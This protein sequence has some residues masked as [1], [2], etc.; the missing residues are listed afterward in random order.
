METDL[1]E[2]LR[3]EETSPSATAVPSARQQQL[4]LA[5]QMMDSIDPQVQSANIQAAMPDV[6]GQINEAA[7]NVGDQINEA[8]QNVQDNV[9]DALTNNPQVQAVA[10][11]YGITPPQPQQPNVLS[12]TGAAIAGGAADAVE[13][14]GGFAE[15]TGDTLKTGINTLFGQPVDQTQNPF[16]ELYQHN[17][18]GWLDIPDHIVP[19]NKTALGKLA[20]GLVEFG[21]LTAAT[22]GVGGATAGGARVGLRVAATARAAGIGARGTRYIKFL[23]KGA[24]VAAE[25]GAAE[26]ISSQSE[27]ANLLNLVDDTTPWMSPWVKNVVGVNALKVHP[28]DNPW[29]A[30]IKTVAVGSGVNLVGW[31]ISAYAKGRWAALDARKQGKSIDEA[32]E[33]GNAKL[34][35]EIQLQ[36]DLDERAATEKAVDQYT[37][38]EGI[39]NA[40]PRD[41][42]L[43]KNLT[44]EEYA[45]YNQPPSPDRP[46][47]LE[48]DELAD[49]RGNAAGDAWDYDA[50]ASKSQLET[51]A[52][53]QP[54][55]WVNPRRFD[56]SERAMFRPEEGN[57]VTRNLKEGVEDMKTGS[58]KGRSYSPLFTETA[59]KQMSRGSRDLREYIVE[60]A[61][62]I[63]REAFKS[64]DNQLNYKEVQELIIRQASEMHSALERGGDIAQE[65]RNWFK[66]SDDNIVWTHAGNEVVTGTASEKAALQLVINTLAKQ[67]EGIATGAI[68]A[69][70]DIPVTRQV[71]QVFDAMKVALTE[72]KKIGYM[73]GSELANMKGLQL[74]PARSRQIGKRL[75]E[76]TQEQ[77]EYFEALHKLNKAGRVEEMKDLMEIHA[78]SKGDVRTLEMVHDWLQ[79]KLFGGDI[80]GGKIRGKMRQEIQGVFYNSILSSLKTPIDAVT[81]TV[82]IGASRP[83]MQYIGAAITRNPKEMAVAAAGLDAIGS[84]YRESIDMA[85]HNWDLGLHR[86]SMSYQGRYD[87][88]GDIAEWQALREHFTRYGTETQKRA[89][90]TLDKLVNMN[91]SPWMKYSANA[92]GAGDAFTR[93]MIGRVNMRMKAAREAVD[94]GVDLNDVNAIARKTEQNFRE[95]IFKKNAEG[96]WV[97]HDK[98]V[99]LAGDEATMTKALE[100]WPKAFEAIQEWPIARAFFPFVRTGVNALDLTFQSSPLAFMH[101]KYKDLSQGIH[102]KDYGLQPHEVA[103]ELAMMQGRMAVGGSITGMAFIATM[104][105]NMTGD[106]PRDKEGRDLWKMAGIQPYSFKIGNAYVSYKELEPWNT[107]FSVSANMVQNGDTLGEAYLDEWTE[108]VAYMASAVLIDKSMLSGVKDLTDIFNPQRSEGALQRVF[109]KYSRAHLPY[110]GLMG[111]LGKIIDG[112]EKE[113]NT[114]LEQMWKR[115]ALVKSTL[116]PKYD[117]L[118]KDR[119]GKPLNFGATNPL[120][121]FKNAFSFMP[122]VPIDGDFVKQSLV[123]I[124]FNLPEVMASYKGVVLNS[125][126]RSQLQKYMS[127]GPLRKELLAIMKNPTWQKELQNYKDLNR[128]ESQ[129]YKLTHQRFYRQ[130]ARAFTRNKD[131]AWQ[132]VLLNNPDLRKAISVSQAKEV[133]SKAGSGYNIQPLRRHGF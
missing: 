121:K 96:K 10:E 86:K 100:G 107:I 119:S 92:M 49:S 39:S 60:V 9:Q 65:L 117:I 88:A 91:T 70:D 129:G 7:Q 52:G 114:F 11:Q 120:L 133:R 45:G 16:S 35:E 26:L 18:A 13:S 76:I 4:D 104:S 102:I 46:Q 108:K 2:E 54:D 80:G 30:R 43:R 90:G 51:D 28:D 68:H 48:L 87:V 58:G 72:H 99:A 20:R 6:G 19:E 62:D 1:N 118:S 25:G 59:L 97:V 12:E 78:L 98:A 29:L 17:D 56:D 36:L 113:A 31:G 127:M 21:L 57:P 22:G 130:V 50:K 42:Y 115:D 69:A 109:S 77:D 101:K 89:Y 47:K 71:E 37:R 111:Q 63:S 41:E 116:Q 61:E 24:Q 125:K 84:A 3:E 131:I 95:K 44:E 14:V 75:E 110:Q 33:I 64:L 53:R 66:N 94:S 106:Y 85:M 132:Q 126:Q 82:M 5:T 128:L 27:D 81:S 74:S 122:V 67:A 23:T 8:S 73:T 38:G 34:D 124:N 112:N 103:G 40:N 93:T 105:G 15:L 123:D 83:M 79:A 55:P 32:N